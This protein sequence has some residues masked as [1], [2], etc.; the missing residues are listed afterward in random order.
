MKKTAEEKIRTGIDKYQYLRKQLE[1]TNVAEDYEYQR[2]FN[3]FFR[4]GRRTEA[5]YAD[6]YTYFE[7]HKIQKIVF[8]DVL[9]FLY[10][11]Q[12]RLEMSFASK[13]VAIIDP[14]FPIWDSVVAGSHFGMKAPCWNEK[15]RV[16]KAIQKY[17]EYCCC[18]NTYLQTD[19]A[20][21]KIA[22]FNINYP[23][24]DITDVKKLDFILWQE[25]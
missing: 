18:Y 14:T 9:R 24:E 20:Q 15:N 11:K 21:A 4:M 19:E 5:F 3:G 25:R 22:I 23:N 2:R 1:Q 8:A 10:E 16:E 12:G 13:M 6:F 17:D 7:Q